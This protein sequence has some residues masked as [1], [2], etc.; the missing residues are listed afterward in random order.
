MIIII[1]GNLFR[2]LIVTVIVLKV[3]VKIIPIVVTPGEIVTFV[4]PEQYW[5]APIPNKVRVGV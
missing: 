2:V 3:I 4:S 5:K 1:G